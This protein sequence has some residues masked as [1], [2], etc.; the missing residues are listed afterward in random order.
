MAP[1]TFP[2]ASITHAGGEFEHAQF[3]EMEDH[4]GRLETTLP[5]HHQLNTT[6]HCRCRSYRLYSTSYPNFPAP[7]HR[8]SRLYFQRLRYSLSPLLVF[9]KATTASSTTS[10][11]CFHARCTI[12]ETNSSLL[13]LSILIASPS[14]SYFL[15]T[16]NLFNPPD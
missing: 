2:P 12:S 8:T 13:K 3:G 11:E 1:S 9:Y 15:K 6:L 16:C 14:S 10:P 7:V 5:F 4:S